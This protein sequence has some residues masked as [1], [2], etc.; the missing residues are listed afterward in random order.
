MISKENRYVVYKIR[1][2]VKTISWILGKL[3]K[4][5][6]MKKP[7]IRVFAKQGMNVQ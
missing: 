6:R 5:E 7:K 1:T 3:V 2:R 4:C